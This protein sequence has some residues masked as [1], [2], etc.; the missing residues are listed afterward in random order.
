[1]LLDIEGTTTPLEF[2]REV[3]FPYARARVE[4][5]FQGQPQS[6]VIEDLEALGR[7]HATDVARGLSPP[8]WGGDSLASQADSATAYVHW[9]MDRDRKSTALKSIQGRV[10]EAGYRSRELRGQVYPDVTPAFLRW[11]MNGKQICIFSS[12]SVLA[13]RLLFESTTDGDLTRFIAGYFDTT[14]GP[15]IRAESYAEIAA[16]MRLQTSDV[17]FVSDT[18]AELDAAISSGMQVVLCARSGRSQPDNENYPIA[19]TFD[20]ILP[21]HES[22]DLAAVFINMAPS[23]S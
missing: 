17:L 20:L 16:R 4:A 22:R 15:K 7:E 14:T 11:S 5:Y 10:W 12:G 13:Q 8:R 19:E 3:L 18:S 6:R 1:V 21:E 9:L 2:V 23:K